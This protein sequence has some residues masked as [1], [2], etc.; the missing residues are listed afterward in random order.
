MAR[1]KSSPIWSV[2]LSSIFLVRSRKICR[3]R[4]ASPSPRETHLSDAAGM[5]VLHGLNWK[6]PETHNS[7]GNQD[8]RH[9]H[10]AKDWV[11]STQNCI[12]TTHWCQWKDSRCKKKHSWAGMKSQNN[13]KQVS[14]KRCGMFCFPRTWQ[15]HLKL[16][17][18]QTKGNRALAPLRARQFPWLLKQWPKYEQSPI[19]R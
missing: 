13:P 1:H 18:T 10:L 12:P 8:V 14:P 15:S 19:M 5:C 3:V 4:V 17:C 7:S 11:V 2:L 9:Y 16:L 6:H